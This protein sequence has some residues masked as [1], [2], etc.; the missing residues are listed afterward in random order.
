MVPSGAI[1]IA[2]NFNFILISLFFGVCYWMLEA[3]RDVIVFRKGDILNRIFTPDPFS[4]WMRLLVIMLLLLFGAYT[5]SLR[6]KTE[7]EG[8]NKTW[9]VRHFGIIYSGIVFGAL[10]WFLASLRDAI[11]LEKANIIQQLIQPDPL[12]VWMRLLAVCIVMLFSIYAQNLFEGREQ[13]KQAL[14]RVNDE[15][16]EIVR[17]RT[18]E[19]SLSNEL[20]KKENAGRERI[21]DE[22]LKVNRALK[23]LSQCN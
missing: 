7:M 14:Q 19:L 15:L 2:K 9:N 5:Q 22:L 23:T 10:Y 11:V 6:D 17:Q 16:E 18:A 4:F 8:K 3:V 21:E 20:L 1:R 13:A 12:S